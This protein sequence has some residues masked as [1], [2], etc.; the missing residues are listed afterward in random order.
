MSEVYG[1]GV[2]V[3][4]LREVSVTMRTIVAERR[5]SNQWEVVAA[6]PDAEEGTTAEGNDRIEIP[7]QI[8]TVVAA[9][10]MK[11]KLQAP[12]QGCLSSLSLLRLWL[13]I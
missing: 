11:T 13:E 3:P 6:W 8:I 7:V 9:S 10:P 5:V 1:V 2:L 4:R 12:F